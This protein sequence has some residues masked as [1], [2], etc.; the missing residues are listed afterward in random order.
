MFFPYKDDNPQ[1]LVPYVTY[2]I[3][4][5]NLLVFLYQFG[6]SDLADLAFTLSFG[7][8]P[9]MVTELS[10]NQIIFSFTQQISSFTAANELIETA[11]PHSPFITI[12][13]SMFIHGGFV[14]IIGNMWFL[15]IFGDNVE[16]ALGHVKYVLF[17]IIC[18]AVA[19]LSQIIMDVNSIIPMVGASGAVSGVLAGYMVKYPRARVH[20][21]IFLFIFFTTIQVPAFIVI[22]IWFLEQLTNGLGSLGLNT[23]GGVA[24]FAHIGGFGAGIALIFAF[25]KIKIAR[26]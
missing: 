9:A 25:S 18:G 23:T 7:L 17:Y 13:T 21:F 15:W 26:I 19:G 5:L 22:G 24:W 3:I 2:G 11:N 1:I 20:V 10:A 4:G 12:F 14:H 8:I 6:L 16:S